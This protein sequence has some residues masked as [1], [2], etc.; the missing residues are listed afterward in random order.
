MHHKKDNPKVL[1]RMRIDSEQIRKA[2]A[3]HYQ[4]FEV[5]EQYEANIL[6]GTQ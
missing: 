4:A 1:S 3:Q 5:V 2:K 6:V